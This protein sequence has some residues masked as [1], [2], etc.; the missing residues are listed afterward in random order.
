MSVIE[1]F[2][3]YHALSPPNTM[4]SPA[5]ESPAI[6]DTPSSWFNTSPNMVDV[7]R[8][9]GTK[10]SPADSHHEDAATYAQTSDL[11]FLQFC[12]TDSTNYARL[13]ARAVL[14]AYRINL[15]PGA[16]QKNRIAAERVV[17]GEGRDLVFRPSF[18]AAGTLWNGEDPRLRRAALTHIL[19]MPSAECKV[20]G[21][22]YRESSCVGCEDPTFGVFAAC[23]HSHDNPL[24]LGCSNCAL[25][26]TPSGCSVRDVKK[27]S[28]QMDQ[29]HRPAERDSR[30]CFPRAAGS[31]MDM[32]NS[33]GLLQESTLG[34]DVRR[35]TL[36]IGPVLNDFFVSRRE[37]APTDF[38]IWMAMRKRAIDY[39]P[40]VLAME[41][42]LAKLWSSVLE[43][44]LGKQK[45]ASFDES[46]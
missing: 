37:G 33:H 40:E 14:A 19:G 46:N 34:S 30:N 31:R 38:D 24:K 44:E 13:F 39:E 5:N 27:K 21:C 16:S 2:V 28:D 26:S 17:Q 43:D 10:V 9:K 4:T 7:R 36:Q 1:G 11:A 32:R 22:P 6:P 15:F 3:D 23:R 18:I 41:C 35:H 8:G 20:E 29:E 25:G 12:P 45:A 42:R